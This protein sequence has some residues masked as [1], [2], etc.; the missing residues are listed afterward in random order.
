MRLF[1]G[2]NSFLPLDKV[3]FAGLMCTHLAAFRTAANI[4]KQGMALPLQ[5][6]RRPSVPKGTT[7]YLTTWND[8]VFDHVDFAYDKE[9][10]LQ[11]VSFTAREG[12]ITALVGPSGS[13]KS[14]CARLAARLWD[15]TGG[16]IRVGGVDIATVDPEML[17]SDYSMVFQEVVLFDD[18]VMENIRLGK[19]GASDAEVIAAAKAA[20]C[21]EFVS[22]LPQ[23]YQTPIGENGA[24]LSGGERQRISI[25]RALLKDAPIVL[26]DEAT[27]SLDVENETKVQEALSRLLTGKT[28]LV[29]AHRMRTVAAA[30]HIVV[31]KEGKVAQ[32]GTPKE[33][34]AQGGLYRRMV[35]LQSESAR[36][37]LKQ[38]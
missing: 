38:A 2:K 26:L 13:G 22:K 7:L 19:R 37:N 25:A 32:Q 34:M 24:K 20:N 33:L 5:K 11:D 9:A 27:A 10:V 16:S 31:L 35:E 21:Q 36:W 29:I 18:T 6:G 1:L 14:T 30:D 15:V 3:Y 8:I 4:R 12:E 23:G 28:V 17:L